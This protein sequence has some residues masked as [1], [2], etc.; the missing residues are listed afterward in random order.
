MRVLRYSNLKG[1]KHSKDRQT[2]NWKTPKEFLIDGEGVCEDFAIA[3][4]FT[5]LELGIP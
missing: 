1:I 3:K 2:N 4:Y 5:L